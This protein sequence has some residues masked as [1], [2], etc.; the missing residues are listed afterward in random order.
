MEPVVIDS[1]APA[2]HTSV[3]FNTESQ[4]NRSSK[5]NK[6]DG[7]RVAVQSISATENGSALGASPTNLRIPKPFSALYITGLGSQYPPF[8]LKPDRLKSFLQKLYDTESPGIKRMLELNQRT[9]IES[10]SIIKALE[11]PFWY[12]SVAPSISELDRVFRRAGVDLAV[13][14][15]RKALREAKLSVEDITHTVAVT[16]TNAGN[17]GFDLLVCQKLGLKPETDRT[18]LHGVGCAGGLSIMRTA[19]TIAQSYS[20]RGCPA[21]ILSFASEICSINVRTDVDQIVEQPD[22][23]KASPVLYSDGAAAFVLCNELA[24][25]AQEQH[26][27][28]LSG[29][30]TT[31]IPNSACDLEVMMNP[32]GFRATLTKEVPNLALNTIEPLFERLRTSM[33]AKSALAPSGKLNNADQ[34]KEFDWALYPSSITV[35]EGLQKMFGLHEEQLKASFDVY[36]NHGVSSSPTVLIVLDRLRKM[37]EG[38][39]NVVACCFGPGITME[40]AMLRRVV[41]NGED[42]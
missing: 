9:M 31:T 35:L 5:T 16:C 17:P 37:G 41:R 15:C 39:E 25:G 27:Y 26:I 4:N 38:R 20:M 29:W 6:K 8:T 34:A 2:V 30:E 1:E 14:A 33:L 11:D 7:S 36:K 22:L 3:T 18:L 23:I 19:A 28:E 32:L 21:R 13:Q 40:M 12:R 24:E 10:R 42:E